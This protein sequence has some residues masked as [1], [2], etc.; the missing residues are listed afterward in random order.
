VF[1]NAD[2]ALNPAHTVARILGRPLEFYRGLR[3]VT[4]RK[5]IA[6]L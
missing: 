1:Q 6:Q 3:G 2:T 5:R 4:R